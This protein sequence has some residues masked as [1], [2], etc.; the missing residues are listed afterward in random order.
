MTSGPSVVV[1]NDN[2]VQLKV[3]TAFKNSLKKEA[4]ESQLV[5]LVVEY[6]KKNIPNYPQLKNSLEFTEHITTVVFDFLP[7]KYS[8]QSE[9]I[10]LKKIVI[11]VMTELYGELS[12]PSSPTADGT[13]FQ[14]PPSID[15]EAIETQVKYFQDNGILKKTSSWKNLYLGTKFFLKKKLN[16]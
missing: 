2:S 15:I 1:L 13:I 9:E 10:D 4:T 3:R 12:A 14:S 16:S 8:K 11:Q 5:Q 7:Q 6:V